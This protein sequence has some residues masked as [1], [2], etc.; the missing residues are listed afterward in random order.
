[1]KLQETDKIGIELELKEWTQ[2][3]E[4][5][6]TVTNLLTLNNFIS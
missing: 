2:D 4:Q 1:M 5:N 6:W 3:L